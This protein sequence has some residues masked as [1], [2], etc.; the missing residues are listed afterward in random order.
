MKIVVGLGN[1]GD[2]YQKTRHN[3]GF[4]FLDYL[5]P[6][7]NAWKFEKKFNAS[8]SEFQG[9]TLIKPQTFMNNSGLSLRSFLDYYQLLPKRLGL[10]L[11]SHLDLS[12]ELIV[13]HDELDLDFTKY[14]RSVN[15]SS[16]GH[17][18]VESIIRHLKT[19]N[20]TRIRLGIKNELK[21]RIAGED[22]VMQKFSN[23]E[24]EQLPVIFSKIDLF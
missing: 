22:F 13:V 23:Q 5:V 8:V 16:A 10:F 15:V 12:S 11:P 7:V 6:E 24:L 18:G 3:F 4:M 2:K 14:K 17:K 19:K 21:S 9:L 20:F 1:P